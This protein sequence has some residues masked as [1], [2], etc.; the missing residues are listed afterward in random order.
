MVKQFRHGVQKIIYEFP[1]GIVD[2]GELPIQAAS[3]ELLEETGYKAGTITLIGNIH[4]CPS[5][6]T[7]TSFTF[8]AQDLTFTGEQHL[9]THE[10]LEPVIMPITTVEDHINKGKEEFSNSQTIVSFHWYKQFMK[11]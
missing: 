2:P 8:I 4:P 6:M 10:L 5:F 11:G 3:R 1:A 9:D 7:N